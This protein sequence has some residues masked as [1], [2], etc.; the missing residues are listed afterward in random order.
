MLE[1][2]DTLTTENAN[3][4][5]ALIL[6][7]LD[8]HKFTTVHCLEYAGYKPEVR[9]HEKLHGGRDDVN[10]SVHHH[11]ETHTQIIL[12]DSYGVDGTSTTQTENRYDPDF[13]APYVT[14]TP[15]EVRWTDRTPAGKLR[16]VVRKIEDERQ[17]YRFVE[18]VVAEFSQTT[19]PA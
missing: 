6:R 8:G 15:T 10:V 5:G 18:D 17:D 13:H 1:W 14:I 11:S 3:L 12:C 9:L 7:C 4:V 16:H 19:Q 2:H